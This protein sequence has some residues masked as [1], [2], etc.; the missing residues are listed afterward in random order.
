MLVQ[1]LVN[2][3]KVS[4][5]QACEA[6]I[7]TRSVWYYKS[8]RRSDVADRRRIGEIANTRIRYG[9]NRIHALSKREGWKD[10]KKRIHRIYKGERPNLCSNS[11]R[12]SKVAAHRIE[13]LNPIKPQQ[14]WSMDFVADQLFNGR[15]FRVLTLLIILVASALQP[16]SDNPSKESM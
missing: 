3:Y 2:Q 13:R 16:G 14:C 11:P 5:R 9:V 6:M 15:K 1:R 8:I 12:R 7:L 10:N 4:T